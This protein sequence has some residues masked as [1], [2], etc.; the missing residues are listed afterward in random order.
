MKTQSFTLARL[1]GVDRRYQVAPDSASDIHDMHW[2]LND[3]WTSCGGFRPVTRS[4]LKYEPWGEDVPDPE[5]IPDDGDS[6][7]ALGGDENDVGQAETE[8]EGASGGPVGSSDDSSDEPSSTTTTTPSS[9]TAT[10]QSLHWFAQHNGARQFLVWEDTNGR[11]RQFRGGTPS[12]PYKNLKD[13]QNKVWNGVDRARSVQRTPG[14]ST[15]SIVW[16]GRL[17]MVNGQD[18][19]IVYDGR[20]TGRA[21]YIQAPGP[22]DAEV[23][24]RDFNEDNTSYWLGTRIRNQ[25]LGSSLPF[26]SG[27]ETGDAKL[28][29]YKYR[30]TFVNR[31]GQE[32]P[33]SEPS[34][35]VQF[36]CGDK[37]KT[38]FVQLQIPSGDVETIARRIYRTRDIF[39]AFGQPT[40]RNYGYNYYFVKEVQDNI[41]TV[42]EDGLSDGNLGSLAD[43]EDFGPWPSQAR[44]IASFKNTVFLAGMPNNQIQFSAPNMPEVFPLNNIFDISEG[45]GGDVTGIYPTKN[46][47]VVFKRRGI[48]LIKGDP[49]NG[50]YVQTLTRDMGCIAVDSVAEVPGVGLVF[51]SDSGIFV[52][53]GAL[54]NTGSATGVTELSI[55]IRDWFDE[56]SDSALAGAVGIVYHRDRE[57]WLCVPGIGETE[58]SIVF[59]FHYTVGAWSR[60]FDVPVRCAVETK[61]H[62]GYLFFGSSDDEFRPGLFVYTHSEI[63]R[64]SN[65]GGT[66]PSVI[67]P[68]YKTSPLAFGSV[69]T[70]VQPAYVNIYAVAR[71]NLGLS[72]N[73]NVNRSTDEAFDTSKTKDQR[74]LIKPNDVYSGDLKY[75]DETKWGYYRPMPFRYDVSLM[76]ESVVTELQLIMTPESSLNPHIEIVGF[77][78]EAKVGAQRDIRILTD[79]LSADRR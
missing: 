78:V 7:D 1:R 63:R 55:P 52:L 22:P 36:E 67:E 3:S 23:V 2:T 54:E 51:L 79:V 9:D 61:D 8:E 37:G 59:V 71:G 69:Y 15:Q 10:I 4:D 70:G 27:D 74:D 30:V 57:F 5:A 11:L 17:Y 66:P 45:D 16:G 6:V 14:A 38:R 13:R 26:D 39:D 42:I 62:R 19:P 58:N 50:F 25:G 32:S 20:V 65:W 35:V 73:L 60:R 47:L 48:Y 77:D 21:G 41:A 56:L 29:G 76:H 75:N 64:G 33:M 40:N 31:R 18:E 53:E 24:L 46:A 43:P 44:F 49:S 28:C 34:G 68:M 72:L 12:A